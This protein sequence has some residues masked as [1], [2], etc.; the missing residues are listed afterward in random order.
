VHNNFAG[1]FFGLSFTKLNTDFTK[2]VKEK[3]S[4]GSKLLVVCQEGLR[5]VKLLHQDIFSQP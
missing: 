3:F 2:T 4:P 5:Y 1:L